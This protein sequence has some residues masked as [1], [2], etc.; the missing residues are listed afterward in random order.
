MLINILTLTTWASIF[1]YICKCGSGS[2][3]R[4]RIQEAPEYGSGFTTLHKTIIASFEC[5]NLIVS[6]FV[7]QCWGSKHI[8]FGSGS[9]I[10]AQ[11]GSESRVFSN[12]FWC[13]RNLTFQLLVFFVRYILYTAYYPI[14]WVL[15]WEQGL[16]LGAYDMPH[17]R[18]IEPTTLESYPLALCF[19]WYS[20]Q[21]AQGF[22]HGLSY[23][24]DQLSVHNLQW[25]QGSS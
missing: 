2:V 9:R 18:G 13:P 20:L 4:I 21:Q 1:F 14:L 15:L 10:L 16:A 6:L 5:S 8:K 22:P 12:Y 7:L 24:R 23:D 11:F 19:F 25:N 17:P 3:F